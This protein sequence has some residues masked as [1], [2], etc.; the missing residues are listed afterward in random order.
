MLSVTTGHV[1]QIA[2]GLWV[3]ALA[4]QFRAFAYPLSLKKASQISKGANSIQNYS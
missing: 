1:W 3:R 4:S 2:I